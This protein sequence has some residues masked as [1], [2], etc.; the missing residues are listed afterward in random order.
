MRLSE[1]P[2]HTYISR[3]LTGV[4]SVDAESVLLSTSAGYLG[5]ADGVQLVSNS[6]FESCCTDQQ[7]VRFF[8]SG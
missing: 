7:L 3:L 2:C 6:S 8:M 4:E 1:P 5:G